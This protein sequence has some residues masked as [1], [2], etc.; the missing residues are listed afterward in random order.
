MSK[1]TWKNDILKMR[2]VM[3]IWLLAGFVL[4]CVPQFTGV[5]LHE[6]LSFLFLVPLMIHML[7]HW[8]WMKNLPKQFMV[9][10][11]GQAR[12]NVIWDLIFYLA[13]MVVI[14]S[15]ILIS[16]VVLPLFG[17]TLPLSPFWFM[18]HDISS[19]LLIPML[20][21][22]LALHWDWIKLMT[23]KMLKKKSAVE[24]VK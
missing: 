23:G 19:N 10:L 5:A 17:L 24:D 9:R 20:G 1:N 3:D 21:I 13:M 22:H 7:L 6:W 12:F 8:D 11:K 15:G 16:E 18:I 14:L 4:V 2:Y